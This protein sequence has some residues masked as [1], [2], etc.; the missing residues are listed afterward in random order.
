MEYRIEIKTKDKI[1]EEV[2]K[3]KRVKALSDDLS[4]VGIME[5]DK[6]IDLAIQKTAQQESQRFLELLERIKNVTKKYSQQIKRH[7]CRRDTGN[8]C[9]DCE[10]ANAKGQGIY[11][12]IEEIKKEIGK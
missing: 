2:L 3:E 1:R 10:I 4:D 11:E 6:A 8:W 5:I 7:R 12:A 9:L